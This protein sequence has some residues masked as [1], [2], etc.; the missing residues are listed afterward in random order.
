MKSTG[1]GLDPLAKPGR[2]GRQRVLRRWRRGTDPESQWPGQGIMRSVRGSREPRKAGPSDG[3]WEPFSF[4]DPI[5]EP[6]F[7]DT[8]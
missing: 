1:Q 8:D 4:L 7:F 2:R 5:M 6:D 3:E